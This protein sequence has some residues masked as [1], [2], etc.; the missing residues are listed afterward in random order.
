MYQGHSAEWKTSIAAH[1]P[2]VRARRVSTTTRAAHCRFSA[3]LAPLAASAQR[4]ES[5]AKLV[6][7]LV[8]VRAQEGKGMRMISLRP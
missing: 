6:G 5:Q 2:Y 7:I 1:L 8:R 3:V 4:Q